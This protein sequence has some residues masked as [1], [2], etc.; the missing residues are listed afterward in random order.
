MKEKE[1]KHTKSILN[2]SRLLLL[3]RIALYLNMVL[4]LTKISPEVHTKIN[5]IT[6]NLLL[7]NWVLIPLISYLQVEFYIG[8][9][10]EYIFQHIYRENSYPDF[11]FNRAS[12]GLAYGI[13]NNLPIC[14]ILHQ[15]LKTWI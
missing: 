3:L 8:N 7:L 2:F 9:T 4:S 5:L 10:G 15:R 12:W 1:Q 6:D 11:L 13:L 14:L